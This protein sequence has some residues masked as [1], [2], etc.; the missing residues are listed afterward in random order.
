[1]SRGYVE[2]TQEDLG[3]DSEPPTK[4]SR[5]AG[6][7]M[8]RVNT[9]AFYTAMRDTKIVSFVVLEIENHLSLIHI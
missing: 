3:E 4:K 2:K 9:Q 7:A 6:G 5:T 8:W 1:M